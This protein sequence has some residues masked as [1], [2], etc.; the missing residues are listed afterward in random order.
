MIDINNP[1]QNRLLAALPA[2]NYEFVSSLLERV[3]VSSG[4]VLYEPGRALSHVYFPVTCIISILSLLKNGASCELAMVG[5]DG[6]VGVWLLMGVESM[7][8][9]AEAVIPGYAYRM[10]R[11]QF[12]EKI[13]QI[14]GQHSGALHGVLHCYIQATI[15]Q[16]AQLAVCNR[17][18]EIDQQLCRWLLMILERQHDSEIT[19]TQQ[20]ISNI[21][22]VRREGVTEAASKL[23]Q[24]GLIRYKRGHI[25]VLDRAALEANSCECYQ[26]IKTEFDRLLPILSKLPPRPTPITA[27]NTYGKNQRHQEALCI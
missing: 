19:V 26:V 11:K 14:G 21:L 15:T 9:Q 6:M 17:H 5:N 12:E 18:H 27:I 3:E 1:K 24:E 16:I 13:K 8:H 10:Q 4:D 25:S 7:P 23:Q 22:G 20:S 2:T